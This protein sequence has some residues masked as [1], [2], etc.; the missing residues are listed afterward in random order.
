MATT[1]PQHGR[2]ERTLY[3][4]V[5]WNLARSVVARRRRQDAQRRTTVG[6]MAGPRRRAPGARV[7]EH[8]GGP[9][10]RPSLDRRL[11][12]RLVGVSRLLRRG[13]GRPADGQARARCPLR[14]P[15]DRAPV[16]ARR[17]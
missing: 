3:I 17:R 16:A 6:A 1:R 11:R 12:A 7:A 4:Y 9:W 15:P 10:P 8:A 2:I 5:T 13:R 14:P